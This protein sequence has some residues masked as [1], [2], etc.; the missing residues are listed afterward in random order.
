MDSG[1]GCVVLGAICT[2]GIESLLESLEVIIVIF[3]LLIK[4]M[5]LL[6]VMLPASDHPVLEFPSWRMQD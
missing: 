3:T 5:E 1:L 2:C 4:I 6:K